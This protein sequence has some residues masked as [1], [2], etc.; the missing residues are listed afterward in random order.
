MFKKSQLN[1]HNNN[2]KPQSVRTWNTMEPLMQ[3]P[4][5]PDDAKQPIMISELKFQT[6]SPQQ[7]RLKCPEKGMLFVFNFKDGINCLSMENGAEF[8]LASFQS[9][10]V[11]NS[12]SE[13]IDLE[14]PEDASYHLCVI[15]VAQFETLGFENDFSLEN[16]QSQNNSHCWFTGYTNIKLSNFI[17]DL[18]SI[19]SALLSNPHLLLGYTNLIIGS[20]LLEYEHD[21][22]APKKQVDLRNDE[23]KRIHECINYIKENYA[24]QL[25][26]DMLCTTVALS[27]RKLQIGVR[28][29]YGNTVTSFIKDFRLQMAEELMRNTEL[30]VSQIVY[31]IGLTS[32][33]YFSKIFKEKYET[34]PNEYIKK[35]KSQ[36][37]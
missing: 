8:H 15:T 24:Q 26:L 25:D 21:I 34:S 11:A 14:F 22:N 6:V 2:S 20:K 7:K 10:M 37:V 29:L 32:R 17:Y 27:P 36:I 35:F 33:S 23:I 9:I 28:E 1:N 12:D 31:S 4:G 16:I 19:E 18:M 3:D 30:N 13:Y 5:A